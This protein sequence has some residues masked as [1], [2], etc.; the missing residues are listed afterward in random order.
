VLLYIL[1]SLTTVPLQH[2]FKLGQTTV[3]ALPPLTHQIAT[4]FNSRH[5]PACTVAA[6]VN[7][8]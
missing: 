2:G 1:G 6:T 5:P 7:L 3:T 4:G 8:T